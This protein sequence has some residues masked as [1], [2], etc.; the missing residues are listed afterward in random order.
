MTEGMNEKSRA[1]RVSNARRNSTNRFEG[2]G[3]SC[4]EIAALAC[5]RGANRSLD[6]SL[7]ITMI[8]SAGLL[9]GARGGPVDVALMG[10]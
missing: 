6:S 9:T 8:R 3:H 5:F 7:L 10:M 4:P 1:L 2:H